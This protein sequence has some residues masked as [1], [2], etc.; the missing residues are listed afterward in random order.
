MNKR[1]N[2]ESHTKFSLT[3][4]FTAQ[5]V[6]DTCWIRNYQGKVAVSMG[7]LNMKNDH[8]AK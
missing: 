8:K 4:V 3:N 7:K 5:D 6:N 2:I 1:A